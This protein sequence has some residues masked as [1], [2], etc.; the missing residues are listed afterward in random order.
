MCHFIANAK[1]FKSSLSGAPGPGTPGQLFG[2]VGVAVGDAVGTAVGAAVGTAV[3]AA[4]GT[5]VCTVMQP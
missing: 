1:D 3:G 5:A 2:V 4:V